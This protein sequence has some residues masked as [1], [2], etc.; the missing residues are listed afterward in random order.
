M[1]VEK[2]NVFYQEKEKGHWVVRWTTDDPARVYEC[3]ARELIAKKINKCAW[4]KSI[5][6]EQLY[7][8]FVRVTV[9]Y[10]NGGRRVYTITE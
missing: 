3:L 1:N 9:A 10:E 8:G 4:V 6:R 7:N 2:I 5:K